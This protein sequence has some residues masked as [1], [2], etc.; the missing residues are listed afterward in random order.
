MCSDLECFSIQQSQDIRF[1]H[2]KMNTPAKP[3]CWDRD[4]LEKFSQFSLLQKV[5]IEEWY[6]RTVD[7]HM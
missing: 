5:E 3:D 4:L 7:E 1:S 6:G 2:R